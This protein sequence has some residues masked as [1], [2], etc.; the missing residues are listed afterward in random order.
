MFKHR[1]GQQQHQFKNNPRGRWGDDDNNNN[2]QQTTTKTFSNKGNQFSFKKTSQNQNEFALEDKLLDD[3]L[4]PTGIAIKP[5]EHLLKDF[6][7][8]AWNL[9]KEKI[10]LYLMKRITPYKEYLNVSEK[11]K[12]LIKCLYVIEYLVEDKV[13]DLYQAFEE[14]QEMFEDIAKVYANCR[15]MVD[16]V[17][18]ILKM[19]RNENEVNDNYYTKVDDKPTEEIRQQP[20]QSNIDLLELGDD[21]GKGNDLFINDN[22]NTSDANTVDL[23]DGIFG[24]N[25]I[26]NNVQKK[27]FNFIKGKNSS[28]NNQMQQQEMPKKKGFNFI[29]TKS[30]SNSIPIQ[31]QNDINNIFTQ[32]QQTIDLLN[33]DMPPQ[34]ETTS[35]LSSIFNTNNT[36]PQETP[37]QT[38]IPTV[39]LTKI[40]PVYSSNPQQPQISFPQQQSNFNYDLVYQNT[41]I[42]KPKTKSN[43][44]FNFVDEMIKPKK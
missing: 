3:I 25:N 14:R 39:D 38:S 37:Q 18:H 1:L 40:S 13:E 22:N 35:P 24:C 32:P 6:T 23:L 33:Q 26:E 17:N 7:K 41:E 4:Q 19:L 44:P 8:R 16:V 36:I 20:M 15:K 27:K 31:Q 42:L 5:A 34:N 21:N 29:K 9:N 10:F 43:D 11:N 12:M 2:N 28:Q 30:A